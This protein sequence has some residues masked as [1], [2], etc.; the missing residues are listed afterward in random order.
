AAAWAASGVG[1]CLTWVWPALPSRP[2]SIVCRVSATVIAQNLCDAPSDRRNS[3][4]L[5][6]SPRG[7]PG[8]RPRTDPVTA[9]SGQGTRTA[10]AD[11]T[12]DEVDP[13]EYGG[14]ESGG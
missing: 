11:S 2:N 14:N 4:R 6:G 12:A 1:N 3:R 5:M 9:R 7:L 13:T 8:G 10:A